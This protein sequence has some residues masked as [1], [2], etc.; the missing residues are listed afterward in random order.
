MYLALLAGGQIIKRI[1]KRTLGLRDEQGLAIFTFEGFDTVN[2]RVIKEQFILNID[3]MDLTDEKK[4]KILR[5][6]I[7]CFQMN[8][9]I[10]N[11]IKPSLF[12]YRRLI[13]FLGMIVFV[14]IL[15]IILLVT[16]IRF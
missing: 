14:L 10:A 7:L 4:D 8:N 11:S 2:K 3:N 13:S 15:L 6:K 12:S 1:V 5:E 9:A 16:A